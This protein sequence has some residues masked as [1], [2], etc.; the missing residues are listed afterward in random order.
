MATRG[1]RDAAAHDHSTVVSEVTGGYDDSIFYPSVEKNQPSESPRLLSQL[2]V[3]EEFTVSLV[4][5]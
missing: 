5:D 2:K 3:L 1:G 4:L